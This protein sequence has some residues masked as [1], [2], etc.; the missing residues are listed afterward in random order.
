MLKIRYQLVNQ[1]KSN[2]PLSEIVVNNK[3]QWIFNYPCTSNFDCTEYE[4]HIPPGVYQIELYGASGG[5]KDNGITGYR[6]NCKCPEIEPIE[7]SM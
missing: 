3:N 1:T 7:Y 4:L 5:Y 2:L 6:S